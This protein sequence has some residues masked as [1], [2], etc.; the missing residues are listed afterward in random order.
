MGI[1]SDDDGTI[2]LAREHYPTRQDAR[3]WFMDF[4]DCAFLEAR[5][6]VDWMRFQPRDWEE[7]WVGCKPDDPGAFKCWRLEAA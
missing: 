2:W 5:V 7:F 4:T 3:R 6:T 1:H